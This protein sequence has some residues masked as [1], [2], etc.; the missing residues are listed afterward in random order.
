VLTLRARV[1]A[2]AGGGDGDAAWWASTGLED[3]PPS[4]RGREV[5]GA[6]TA[7]AHLPRS[8]ESGSGWWWW[9]WR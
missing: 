7:R 2:G 5:T 8:S 9:W 6:V 4:F 3:P 1:R